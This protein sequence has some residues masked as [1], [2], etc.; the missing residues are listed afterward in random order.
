MNQSI[1]FS[2]LVKINNVGTNIAKPTTE[3]TSEDFSFI[4]STNVESAYHFSQLAHPLLKASGAGSILFLSS[5]AGVTSVN[6]GSIYG[7]TKGAV[8]YTHKSFNSKSRS[9]FLETALILCAGAINQLTK[10]LACEWAKDGIRVN[11]VAP[12][13]MWTPLAEIVSF[14]VLIII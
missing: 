12:Y 10:N 3:Y 11:S 8:R 6:I 1:S 14:V 2:L 9:L 7:S 13:F 5:V 4:M